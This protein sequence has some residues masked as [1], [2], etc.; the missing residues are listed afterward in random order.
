MPRHCVAVSGDDRRSGGMVIRREYSVARTPGDGSR[1]ARR[2]A[3]LTGW[4]M[5]TA[6][7]SP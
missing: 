5:L 4:L 6:R 7:V 3:A 1:R 2:I